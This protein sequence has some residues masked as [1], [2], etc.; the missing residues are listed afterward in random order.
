M[1][2][3]PADTGQVARML[4]AVCA[5]AAVAA[6]AAVV[7]ALAGR[8]TNP[9]REVGGAGA[10]AGQR[11]RATSALAGRLPCSWAL[12]GLLPP[13]LPALPKL[14]AAACEN[15]VVVTDAVCVAVVMA[16]GAGAANVSSKPR[17]GASSSAMRSSEASR[18]P[19]GRYSSSAPPSSPACAR[20]GLRA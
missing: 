18:S 16:T 5:G 8:L 4:V 1:W 11:V 20:Y 13:A 17:M 19:T 6:A 9:G 14:D 7:R 15:T 3:A 10:A 12:A 2:S